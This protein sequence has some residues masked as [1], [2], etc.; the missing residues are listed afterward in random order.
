MYKDRGVVRDS[1]LAMHHNKIMYQKEK[2]KLSTMM[3]IARSILKEEGLFDKYHVKAVYTVLYVISRLLMK[4][5]MIESL[6]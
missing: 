3:D 6:P 2:I 1:S 4:L 5:G